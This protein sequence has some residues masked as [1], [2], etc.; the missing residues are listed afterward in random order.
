VELIGVETADDVWEIGS[1]AAED[2][3]HPDVVTAAIREGSSF[4]KKFTD[5]TVARVVFNSVVDGKAFFSGI[6]SS[7]SAESSSTDV[8]A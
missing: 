8:L 2:V 7:A 4:N 3:E 1:A 6:R 5:F